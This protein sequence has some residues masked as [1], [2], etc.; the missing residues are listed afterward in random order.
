MKKPELQK[1][2]SGRWEVMRVLDVS[3]HLGANE[4]VIYHTLVAIWHDVN[5]QWIR[6]QLA[7]L[8]SR[9]LIEVERHEIKDWSAKLTHHGWDITK[10]V[11]ECLPGIA[12]PPK[13]WG[14]GES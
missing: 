14:D 3:G 2:E 1:L 12:R 4:T 9:K 11:V 5:R 6:D 10:Y 13:Y 8:E 7:Y